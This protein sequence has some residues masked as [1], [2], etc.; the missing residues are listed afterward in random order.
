MSYLEDV[1]ARELHDVLTQVDE[2]KPAQRVLAGIAYKDGVEQQTIAD[3]HGVHPNTVRNW[4]QRL[5]RLEDEPFRDV[6]YDDPR[7]GQSRELAEAEHERFREAL[8]GPP[9][10]VSL[11]GRVW[12]VPLAQRYLDETFDV[13]YSPRHI[14]RL[15]SEAGLAPRTVR[16][17][18]MEQ[19]E[20]VESDDRGRKRTAKRRTV[21]TTETDN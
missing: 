18:Q 7:P 6:V 13:A 1:T 8:H 2:K 15:L 5:E 4:L 9:E 20:Q 10:A 3:R 14:R 11:E 21:W 19:V 17:E 16:T 12:T